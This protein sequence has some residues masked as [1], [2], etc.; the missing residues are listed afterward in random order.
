MPKSPK[1]PREM[2]LDLQ[3]PWQ[4]FGHF[5]CA[6]VCHSNFRLFPTAPSPGPTGHKYHQSCP[7]S[8]G[9]TTAGPRYPG[10]SADS[11]PKN[12]CCRL[13][14]NRRRLA[15]NCRRSSANRRRLS[16]N[17]RR[18]HVD[19][20]RLRVNRRRL[21]VNRRRSHVDSRR[22]RVNRR[23]LSV[24]RRRSHVNS[25]RLRV[26]R[27]RFFP[28]SVLKDSPAQH[29]AHRLT[30]DA[31]ENA[32]TPRARAPGVMM[33]MKLNGHCSETCRPTASISSSSCDGTPERRAPP[34]M[35][36]KGRGLRGGPRG[37]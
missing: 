33:R 4:N 36:Q 7:C 11:Q 19:S 21:S 28:T 9:K 34:G 3:I 15:I 14:A 26:N 32:T 31:A 29:A 35:H 6:K 12:N 5:C 25:R 18:S 2:A 37:G 27:R 10:N 17:R 16:V 1:T 22:L 24:N 20:R 30:C 13:P 23:R 8:Q